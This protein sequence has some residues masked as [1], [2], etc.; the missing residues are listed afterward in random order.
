MAVLSDIIFVMLTE[1]TDT[2]ALLIVVMLSYPVIPNRCSYYLKLETDEQSV[3]VL[4]NHQHTLTMGTEF[5]LET[6]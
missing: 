1:G 5:G 6:S 2:L 4:L 3:L